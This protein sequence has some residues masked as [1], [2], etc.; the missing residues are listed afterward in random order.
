MKNRLIW[1]VVLLVAGAGC[2]GSGA[3]TGSW[4][5]QGDGTYRNPMLNADYPDVDIERVGD[6]YYMITST[7][8]Y[9][10]GMTLLESKDMLNWRIIGHVWDKLTW[11]P[12]YNWD[13]MA[14]YR[15]GVWAGDLAYHDGKWFCYFIDFSSGLYVSTA[16]DIRG[17]WSE[18]VCML[19]KQFWT[20][21]AVYWDEEEKQAYLI[22]NFGQDKS[23]KQK[24]N[25][26][27]IFKMS[28]D[29]L[30]LLDEG[31]PIYSAPGAEAAKI[32]KIDGT[33]YIFLAEWRDND[34]K[35]IVLRGKTIYGPFERKVVMEKGSVVDRSV[36]QGAL[37]QVQDGSWWFT[38]QLVQNRAKK[39][40]D[41]AGATTGESY[42]GRSQ[43]L[44]PVTW[45]DGWPVLGKDADGNGIGNTV[46]S[47]R[48]PVKGF[49]IT[50]PQ[51]DDE[52]DS[53][54]LGGQWQWNH[55]PR[56]DHWSLTDRP[57]WLRLKAAVPVGDGGFWNAANTISQRIMGKGKGSVI[58]KADISGM[59]AGQQAGFCHHSGQYILLGIRVEPDGAKRL[60][61]NN[62][63]K[64]TEGPMVTA[65]II[66]FHTEIDGD[67][68]TLAWSLDGKDAK[69]LGG[70][71]A[72][73]F[74]RW[75]GDR[76]G[77][78]CFNNKTDAGHIDIDWF[79]YNYDGPKGR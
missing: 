47:G 68:A 52:F 10:P 57:G 53:P 11:E 24:Q 8:H 60:S 66:Y 50:A 62:N 67:R 25:Q 21:P 5:D 69:Q 35:Q 34:R 36:C 55:N 3:Q 22:C 20:D 46:F 15:H 19:K 38:H 75:R 61:F 31:K 41:L 56:D 33:F 26:N 44:I 39:K 70:Q 77:L 74:G 42:E 27:R 71:F 6:M 54:K 48:K 13:K 59:E 2:A 1:L 65:E 63:G 9:A 51:T 7:N 76:L 30:R 37:V 28:W 43:W 17:P 29:G 73:K 45:K 79:H 23:V 78:Y 32:Y 12:K 14:G 18:P 49:P 58:A 40:G 4:G 16:E 64:I 72:L